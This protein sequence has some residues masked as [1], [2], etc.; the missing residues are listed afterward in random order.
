[1]PILKDLIF[2]EDSKVKTTSTDQRKH[3]NSGYEKVPLPHAG[4][5]EFAISAFNDPLFTFNASPQINDFNGDIGSSLKQKT[6][7]GQAI[8]ICCEISRI[9]FYY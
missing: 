8:L 5:I 6:A 7:L 2:I 9:T 1:M 3:K 4:G